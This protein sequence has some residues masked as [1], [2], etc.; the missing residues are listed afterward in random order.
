[1]RS[2]ASFKVDRLRRRLTLALGVLL[3]G[4]MRYQRTLLIGM[5]MCLMASTACQAK[6]S[7]WSYGDDPMEG[8]SCSQSAAELSH[9]NVRLS[10]DFKLACVAL[11]N[12]TA[13]GSEP[14]DFVHTRF[15]LENPPSGWY[16]NGRI[17]LKG[18]AELT[19]TVNYDPGPAG[20]LR[21]GPDTAP[22]APPESAIASYAAELKLPTDDGNHAPPQYRVP[23]SVRGTCWSAIARIRVKGID[24]LLGDSD[25]AGAY[26]VQYVVV[27]TSHFKPHR[28]G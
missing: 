1:M 26:P 19:G 5:I 11:T 14:I 10:G 21:F 12:M 22:I 18:Q 15:S 27:S 13:N 3:G 8:L 20:G 7:R 23:A 24:I 17:L 9:V 4:P 28:C 25:E 16:L 2:S 6:G